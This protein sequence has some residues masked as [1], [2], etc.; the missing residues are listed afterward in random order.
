MTDNPTPYTVSELS[1]FACWLDACNT[2]TP[3]EMV[4]DGDDFV[5]IAMAPKSSEP[6]RLDVN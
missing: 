3:H 6:Q 4:R 1:E 2:F 5:I